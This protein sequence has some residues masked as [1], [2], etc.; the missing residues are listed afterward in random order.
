LIVQKSVAQRSAERE[1][2]VAMKR[3]AVH[4]GL[5]GAFLFANALSVSPQLHERVHPDANQSNH[6]C[7]ITLIA[8][9]NY[10]HATADPLIGIPAP[11]IKFYDLATLDST[12]VPSPFLGASI[13]EHAPPVFV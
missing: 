12:W 13:F 1:G 9:G 6:E 5:I 3:I 7:A 4:F 10:H 8:A 11:A 2:R